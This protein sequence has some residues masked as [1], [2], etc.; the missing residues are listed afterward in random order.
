MITKTYKISSI[1][2]KVMQQESNFKIL[3]QLDTDNFANKGIARID[4]GDT[5]EK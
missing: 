3:I 1:N 2:N 5:S 4:I